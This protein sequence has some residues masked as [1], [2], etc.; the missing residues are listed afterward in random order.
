MKHNHYSIG[1]REANE[2]DSPLWKD[3]LALAIV[4]VIVI[5]L[6]AFALYRITNKW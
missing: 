5:G 4:H 3:L 6:V 2:F 1:W